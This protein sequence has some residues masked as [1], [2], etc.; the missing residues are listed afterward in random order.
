MLSRWN[1]SI[2]LVFLILVVETAS[3]GALCDHILPDTDYVMCINPLID[4]VHY[5]CCDMSISDTNTDSTGFFTEKYD[6]S[7]YSQGISLLSYVF[8]NEGN[9]S[10]FKFAALITAPK[11]TTILRC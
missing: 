8:Q 7:L 9:Q 1:V 10:C 3:G 5:E 11:R 4:N 2:L 6:E